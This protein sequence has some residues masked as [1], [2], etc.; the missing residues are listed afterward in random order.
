MSNGISEATVREWI[1]DDL[2]AGVES[3]T[4]EHAEFNLVV[5]LSGIMV[6]LIRRR[7]GGPLLVGQQI[8]FDDEIRRRLGALSPDERAELLGRVRRA[9][10]ETGIVYGFRNQRGENVSF[11]EMHHV[12]LERRVYP[13]SASQQAVMDALIEVW[14]TL[15]YLDDMPELIDRVAGTD[16]TGTN[17]TN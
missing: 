10:M 12:F 15:R 3:M 1:D 9:L 16:G 14:K 6:H 11:E 2:V 4:D 13:D 17:G 5:Q 8:E 7:D